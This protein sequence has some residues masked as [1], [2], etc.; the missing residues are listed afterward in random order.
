MPI[1]FQ[2]LVRWKGFFPARMKFFFT[3]VALV[4]CLVAQGQ[5]SLDTD[6]S[7]VPKIG[8][9]DRGSYILVG[10]PMASGTTISIIPNLTR[11]ANAQGRPTV[12]NVSSFY[13]IGLFLRRF[14]AEVGVNFSLPMEFSTRNNSAAIGHTFS[15][16]N[17]LIGYT[18]SKNRNR[19]WNIYA[20]IGQFT[21]N[22]LIVRA[23]NTSID[24]NQ[25]LTTPIVGQSPLFVHRSTC[26][27]LSIENTFRQKKAV[28]FGTS[29][30]LG[31]RRGMRKKAWESDFM[32]LQ[33]APTEQITQIFFH[34]AFLISRANKR[35]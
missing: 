21:S 26:A 27:E 15:Y 1:P 6:S 10:P 14:R 18:F 11:L 22:A 20:G 33:N 28:G 9:Y 4:W 34:G 25:A 19:I 31:V 32:N 29:L 23:S 17:G 12:L 16:T 7:T 3:L 24:F 5:I 2:R 35:K 13:K 30:A 8:D